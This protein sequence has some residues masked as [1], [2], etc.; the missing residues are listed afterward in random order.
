MGSQGRTG[1]MRSSLD[2]PDLTAWRRLPGYSDLVARLLIQA[3]RLLDHQPVRA[4]ELVAPTFALTMALPQR[5]RV[6]YLHARGFAALNLRTACLE[7]LD[8]ACAVADALDDVSALSA[9]LYLRASSNYLLF[10]YRAA[11]EEFRACL[12]L[13]R[14]QALNGQPVA[15]LDVAHVL[16][17]EANIRFHLG[18]YA[19]AERLLGQARKLVPRGAGQSAEAAMIHWL[20]AL[21]HRWRGE[22]EPALAQVQF[23]ARIYQ[24]RGPSASL[25]RIQ[26]I[27]AEAA[28]DLAQ[29]QSG[30][31]MSSLML[32]SAT[33]QLDLALQASQQVGDAPGEVLIRLI[34]TR[35]G[36]LRHE[37]LGRV[38][39]IEV[40]ARDGRQLRD[41]ALLAHAFTALGD[42]LVALGEQE[43]GLNSYRQVMGLLDGS[44]V[45]ALAIWARRAYHQTREWQT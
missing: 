45:P 43:S 8:D 39:L 31:T 29:Q 3:Y 24:Q 33:A 22:P 17:H 35:A 14:L 42:E 30:C 38:G 4:A 18:D 36:R 40:L 5:L 41:D 25:V 12:A 2:I 23:A 16:T 21:L 28:L 7:A 26:A 13:L 10:R 27:A 1:A 20:Q 15:A 6:F 19:A 11:A 32:E 44:E 37:N 9:L 34:Q